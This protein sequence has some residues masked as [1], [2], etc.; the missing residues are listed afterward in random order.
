MA[1]LAFKI[2]FWTVIALVIVFSFGMLVLGTI[3]A[4]I[5]WFAKVAGWR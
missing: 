2:V 4:I 3:S 1:E 5:T